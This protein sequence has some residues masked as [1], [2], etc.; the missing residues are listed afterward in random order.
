MERTK[1]LEIVKKHLTE[2]RFIHTLGVEE[3]SLTLAQKYGVDQK[4]AETAAIF[5]DYAKFRPKDEMRDIVRSQGL[6]QDLLYYG[7]EVLH[8]PVGA[9]LVEKGSWSNRQRCFKCYLLPYN[10]SRSND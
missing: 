2:H 5:H 6:S 4:K 3:T 7:N 8:A 1:A 9:F 10:G